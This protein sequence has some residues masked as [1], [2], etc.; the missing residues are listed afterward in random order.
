LNDAPPQSP[1]RTRVVVAGGGT[2]GWLAAAAVSRQLGGLIDVTLVESDEIGTVGVGEAT[3]PTIR[4]FHEIAGVDE[5]AFVAATGATVKLGIAFEDWAC[6]GDRYFHSFGTLGRGTWMGDFHHFWLEARALGFGGEVGEYC[7]EHQAG[8]AGRYGGGEGGGGDPELS[9]AYHLDATAYARHLRA[10]SE[11][12]GA[13]RVEGRIADVRRDAETGDIAGLVLA[14]GREVAGDLFLDCTGFRALLMEG[15][16]GVGYEDW[17]RWLR[18][19]RALAVQ[20]PVAGPPPPYTRARAHTAGWGWRI[21]LRHRVGNGLVYSSEYL[22]DEEGRSR[23]LENLTGDPLFEPRLI[24]YRAGRRE[25]MWA[26]NCVALGLS[27]GFVEPL[28]STSLHLVMTGVTRLMQCLPFGRPADAARRRYN[29]QGRAELEGVRDFVILHYRLNERP[30][31]FWRAC[32]ETPVPDT[33]AERIALFREGAEAYQAGDELFRVDS[34]VQVMLGQRLHPAAHHRMAGLMGEA[35][36]RDVLGRMRAGVAA[37][38]AALP[39]HGDWLA[40]TYPE[41]T[42]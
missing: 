20:T 19:D 9:Y 24:R 37:R 8:L 39:A 25:Q 17:G 12:A 34:W 3:I 32:R 14:D 21:P 5:R 6:A 30:E 10:L 27:S 42:A 38:V 36:L 11:A 41:K 26:H 23:L 15:A 7:A 33:L 16:L 40:R 13:T 31:P 28:E 35:R 4:R 2:A 1:P 29:A 22:S 18:T